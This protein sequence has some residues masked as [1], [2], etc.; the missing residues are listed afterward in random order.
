MRHFLGASPHG[1]YLTVLASTHT[2]CQSRHR[3]AR[4]APVT[5]SWRIIGHRPLIGPC[6][7]VCVSRAVYYH[8]AVR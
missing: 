5:A 7:C 8:T 6:P 3:R 4:V 2:S 1:D